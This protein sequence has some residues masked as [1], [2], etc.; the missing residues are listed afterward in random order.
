MGNMS[1]KIRPVLRFQRA[2]M[3]VIFY[4]TGKKVRKKYNCVYY[5]EDRTP[6]S[7]D[8]QRTEQ[9]HKRKKEKERIRTAGKVLANPAILIATFRAVY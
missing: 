4:V 1:E 5:N 9:R 2:P 7:R 3:V 8:Y 6:P